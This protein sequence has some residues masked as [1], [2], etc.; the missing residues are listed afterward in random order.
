M[1]KRQNAFWQRIAG[2]YGGMMHRSAPLY[3]EICH[4][5]RPYLT[6]EMEVLELACGTGQLSFPLAGSVRRWEATDF[7][8]NMI[9]Q[10]EKRAV[11]APLHFAVR[12]ATDLPY[13]PESFDAVVIANA[14]HIMPNPDSALAEIRRVLR[15]SGWLFAPTFVHGGG[16][17]ARLRTGIMELTGFRAYHR[18]SGE[19]F[20]AY[21]TRQ[22]FQVKES[23]MLGGRTL[24]LCCAVCRWAPPQG[25][26]KCPGIL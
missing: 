8:P 10:A 14:L 26:T 1:E 22:G 13:A 16:A 18:W 25:R 9:A 2:I 24:P 5:I 3:E 21:L 17:L 6:E 15:P 11:P 23:P 19:S 4:C 12:D 20:A 7:S